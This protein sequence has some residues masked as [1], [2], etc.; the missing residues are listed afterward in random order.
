MLREGAPLVWRGTVCF[1]YLA[2]IVCKCASLSGT[3]VGSV[4]PAQQMSAS[5][6][7]ISMLECP[8]PDGDDYDLR[9]CP[10]ARLGRVSRECCGMG[11]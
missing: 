5:T 1:L 3:L 4:I 11:I 6:L 10:A 2:V 8:T 9:R 7:S